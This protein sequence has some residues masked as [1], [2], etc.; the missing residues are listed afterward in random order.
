MTQQVKYDIATPCTAVYII[1]RKADKIAFL[2]RSNTGW[3]DGHY[4]L[5]AG[6]V[7]KE[8]N[9]IRA[10]IREAKEE[11]G[12]DIEPEK[13]KL[14]LTGHRTHTDLDWV[15]IVFEAI[16]WSGELQ[17][18]EPNVHSELRW[19]A[20]NNMPKNTV[21]YVRLYI[22]ELTAGKNYAEF[23]WDNSEIKA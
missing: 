23:G 16:D 8:E 17:N 13:L 4:G 21:A 20:P 14:I 7:E 18:A 19:F 12:V 1:F 5:P 22:E 9:F 11:V 3:M 10:A 6:K 2:M 15:D